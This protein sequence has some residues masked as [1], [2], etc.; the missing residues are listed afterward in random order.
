MNTKLAE[1]LAPISG[2]A[3]LKMTAATALRAN[4]MSPTAATRPFMH[5]VMRDL[6]QI[7]ALLNITPTEFERRALEYLRREHADMKPPVRV[8]PHVRKPAHQVDPNIR[9]SA[10]LKVANHVADVIMMIDG[11][12]IREWTVGQCLTAGRRKSHEAYVLRVIGNQYR[13]LDHTKKIG[14]LMTDAVLK[15]IVE[16][17]RAHAEQG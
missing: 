8:A 12:D 9:R 14:D 11:Q 5:E 6:S 2:P 13:H 3:K 1:Q 15:S 7:L 10:M 4:D 16:Q 17:G